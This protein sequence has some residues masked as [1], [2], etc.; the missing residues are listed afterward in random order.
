MLQSG[1]EML[2][3]Q[4]V[5]C[6]LQYIVSKLTDVEIICDEVVNL[7]DLTLLNLLTDAVVAL[8]SLYRLTPYLCRQIP[9]LRRALVPTAAT[10]QQVGFRGVNTLSYVVRNRCFK[11]MLYSIVDITIATLLQVLP[12][13]SIS[14]KGVGRCLFGGI[15]QKGYN[16]VTTN[17]LRDVLL[18]VVGFYLK[19]LF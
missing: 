11:P 13:A 5:V 19:T 1:I 15:Q 4:M 14:L 2:Y 7:C 10:F 8:K 9:R 3:Q 18:G 6:L 16:R 17:I 12:N